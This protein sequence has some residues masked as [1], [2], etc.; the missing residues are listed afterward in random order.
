MSLCSNVA[1]ARVVGESSKRYA[2]V[3]LD[4]FADHAGFADDDSGSVVDE[5]VSSD[6]R[7]GVNVDAGVLLGGFGHDSGHDALVQLVAGVCDSVS[8]EREDGRE[9]R[10]D[11]A[12]TRRR[13]IAFEGRVRR[14]GRPSA[15]SREVLGE[16]S[17]PFAFPIRAA[18]MP[19]TTWRSLSRWSVGV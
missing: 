2:V 16:D 3:E 6:L 17:R 10:D 19:W 18:A 13:W 1:P 8:R 7:A 5:E 14:R 12:V 4:A 15:G 9:G 11:L